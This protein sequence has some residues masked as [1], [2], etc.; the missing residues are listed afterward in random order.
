MLPTHTEFCWRTGEPHYWW[1]AFL[2]APMGTPTT[3]PRF[4]EPRECCRDCGQPRPTVNEGDN[5][6]TDQ[7]DD[8]RGTGGVE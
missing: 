4:T 2:S 8:V 7:P 6:P 1:P 3:D 5:E